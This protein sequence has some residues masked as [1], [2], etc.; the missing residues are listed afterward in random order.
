QRVTPG[1][2]IDE[3]DTRKILRLTNNFYCFCSTAADAIFCIEKESSALLNGN[4]DKEPQ[5][6]DVVL[7][8][9][10]AMRR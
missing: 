1:L 4:N 7:Q 6:I 2:V 5:F 8:L 10:L 9:L 3:T